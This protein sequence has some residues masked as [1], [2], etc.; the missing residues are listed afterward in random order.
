MESPPI[1]KVTARIAGLLHLERELHGYVSA[2]EAAQAADLAQIPPELRVRIEARA[3]VIRDIQRLIAESQIRHSE[4]RPELV[5]R[6][7]P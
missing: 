5:E 4:Q 2:L 3:G 7:Q 6:Q 1:D